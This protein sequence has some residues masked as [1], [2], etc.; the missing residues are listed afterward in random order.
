MFTAAQR[1]RLLILA[2]S[3]T[4]CPPPCQD[5]VSNCHASSSSTA[6][7]KFEAS[8]NFTPGSDCKTLVL[9]FQTCCSPFV[10]NATR[11]LLDVTVARRTFA[12]NNIGNER[13]SP[14]VKSMS[15]AL[16]KTVGCLV[17]VVLLSRLDFPV[18]A[19]TLDP[20]AIEAAIGT[21]PAKHQQGAEKER[22]SAQT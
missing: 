5:R 2:G 20:F 3:A 9:F 12:S 15:S 1:H 16:S 10:E 6:T 19:G 14:Q 22:L 7:D 21:P 13:G 8:H 11:R 18:F 4:C 17:G